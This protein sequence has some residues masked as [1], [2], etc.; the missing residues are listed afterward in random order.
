MS[1]WD[2]TCS[3]YLY[4]YLEFSIT[5]MKKVMKERLNGSSGICRAIV[6]NWGLTFKEDFLMGLPL[7]QR[8]E[9]S[10]VEDTLGRGRHEY[11]R[12]GS[13]LWDRSRKGASLVGTEGEGDCAKRGCRGRG[14]CRCFGAVLRIFILRSV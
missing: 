8:A 9:G 11:S 1:T 13:S 5:K 4:V 14:G 6:C 7:E 3:V 12:E 2:C 10:L